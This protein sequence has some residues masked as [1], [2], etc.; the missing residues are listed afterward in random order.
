MTINSMHAREM[1]K[2]LTVYKSLPHIK[3]SQKSC[4]KEVPAKYRAS[5]V[6]NQNPLETRV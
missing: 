4:H 6:R 5:K 1:T 3:C 2:K